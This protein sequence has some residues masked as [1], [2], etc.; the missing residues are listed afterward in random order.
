[1]RWCLLLI[2]AQG[3][4]QA[5]L[6]ASGA[7]P[8]RLGTAG[9]ISAEEGSSVTLQCHLSSTSAT[10]TQVDW[11]QQGRFLAI[12]HAES[13]W[14]V[15]PAFRER[16]VPRPDLGL[17]L[18]ALTAN[19][20]GVYSCIYHTFPD[21]IYRGRLFLEVLRSSGA[22]HLPG[23]LL[24]L[25]GV[26]LLVVICTVVT[27]VVMLARKKKFLRIRSAESGLR[28]VPC[29]QEEWEL[30]VPAAPASCV[31]VEAAAAGSGSCREQRDDD[32][33]EPHDYFNVLSY[34][35]LGDIS[36]PAETG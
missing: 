33:D 12:H 30:R 7:V 22:G 5:P 10:V 19:D 27:A 26:L 6:L 18:Q 14:S 28:S 16:V 9:N 13:G 2:W 8:G 29:G 34:R 20:T 24:P 31:G 15:Y 17:T 23:L 1:M 21:G 32:Y 36:F 35:S 4:R 11:T 3:L 25:L